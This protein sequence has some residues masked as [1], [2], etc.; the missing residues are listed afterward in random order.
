MRIEKLYSRYQK[1]IDDYDDFIDYLKKPLKKSFRLNTLK[2][3]KNDILRMVID[4]KAQPLSFYNDGYTTDQRISLGN[5]IAHNLGL[6][7]A[8]EVA[9]MLPV[10]LLDPKPDE[11]VLDVCA[12]PGSKSTQIAQAMKN[13]GFLLINEIS[14]NRIAGLVHNVKRC[15]LLNEVIINIPG[16]RLG[17]VLPDYF[18]RVLIDAP[19]SAEGTIR[20]SKAV[21]FHW[22]LKNI[23]RMSKIQ[24]GLIVSG[25][26]TLR[27]GGLM[28]YS[29]CTIAPEEN[30]V[31]VNYLLEKHAQADLLPVEFP[32]FKSRPGISNWEGEHFD[33]RIKNC[34][35]ILPQDNDTAPF[36]VALISKRGFRRPRT[37]FLGRVEFYENIPKLLFHRFGIKQ[38]SLRNYA[39]FRDKDMYFLA[40]NQSY[41]FRELKPI[42]K[43]L[44]LGK[45]YEQDLKPDNDFIQIFGNNA[46]NNVYSI[47]DHELKGF[48]KGEIIKT[49]QHPGLNNGFIIINYKGLPIGIGRYNGRELKSSIKRERRIPYNC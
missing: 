39:L 13:S 43:G 18:D 36:F 46:S 12:S 32:G 34:V 48:L 45:V 22:G 21:L 5:H 30:E 31:V 16:Q 44:E 28:V 9:S 41:L 47:K 38:D 2:A 42:R 37:E 19:C 40:T 33:K 11:Y 14:R 27:S 8:Q 17:R 29:T 20:R 10:V 24:K 15:G 49:G 35:R 7:Y 23:K 26:N 1:I 3:K 4:L 6:I 25:F